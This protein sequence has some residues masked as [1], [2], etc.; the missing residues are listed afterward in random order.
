[1]MYEAL[2]ARIQYHIQKANFMGLK[3]HESTR[4]LNEAAD[5]IEELQKQ[6][7]EEK[8]DNV[9]LTGWLAEEH[10]RAEE[11]KGKNMKYMLAVANQSRWITVT[12]RL[13]EKYDRVLVYSKATRMGRSIDFINSDGNWYT[14]PK[15]THWMPLPQPPKENE[16]GL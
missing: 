9:N 12:E 3:E 2:V 7:R 4:L 14:T 16:H 8:V 6:L 15:V 10:A 11:A 1:M 13:P 5:A